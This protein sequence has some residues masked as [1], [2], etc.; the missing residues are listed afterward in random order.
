[1]PAHLAMP[2]STEELLQST[3]TLVVLASVSSAT[4]TLQLLLSVLLLP[5]YNCARAIVAV[6]LET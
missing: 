5:S 3:D 1:M 6:R 2:P 4:S